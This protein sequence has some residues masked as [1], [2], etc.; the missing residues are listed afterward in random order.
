VQIPVVREVSLPMKWT[1]GG[2][3]PASYAR[4]RIQ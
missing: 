1:L 4:Y 3:I 2:K